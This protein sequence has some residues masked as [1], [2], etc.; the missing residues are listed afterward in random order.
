MSNNNNLAQVTDTMLQIYTLLEEEGGEITP[1]LEEILVITKENLDTKVQQ[2]NT[3]INNNNYN[4]QAIDA[5]I[6]RLKNLKSCNDKLNE[7]LEEKLLK[8]VQTLGVDVKGVFTLNLPTITLKTRK[9]SSIEVI[10]S[11]DD[12]FIQTDFKV[13][14]LDTDMATKL[15]NLLESKG[16]KFTPTAK[17]SKTLIKEA[18]KAGETVLNAREETSYNLVIK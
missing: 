3:I 11:V 12:K 13:S 2:Y 1:E 14:N 5:E 7:I 4:N 10:G 18:L 16:I 6:G 17:V 8:A 15:A 9:S